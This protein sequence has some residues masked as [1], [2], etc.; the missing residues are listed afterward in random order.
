MRRRGRPGAQRVARPRGRSALEARE[1]DP[2]RP[3]RGRPDRE[4]EVLH[5]GEPVVADLARIPGRGDAGAVVELGV[6]VL[7]KSRPRAQLG[8]A[9]GLVFDA[10]QQ[11]TAQLAVP[12]EQLVVGVELV[13]DVRRTHQAFDPDHLVHLVAH[14]LP[15]LEQESE[16]VAHLHAARVLG[17]HRGRPER[18]AP[19]GVGH[20]VE[21][22]LAG[23]GSHSS[24]LSSA[25]T[26]VGNPSGR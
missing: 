24:S 25:G 26:F 20:V 12:A 21:D 16:R 14:G 9:L 2:E 17:L 5:R 18:V 23:H 22:L 8:V 10:D 4:L 1:R 19:V 3:R 7:Q 6:H 15:V 11:G 13:L